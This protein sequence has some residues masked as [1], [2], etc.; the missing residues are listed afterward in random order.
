MEE[1]KESSIS[2]EDFANVRTI[3]ICALITIVITTIVEQTCL[4]QE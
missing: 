3:E 1:E 4:V 2:N